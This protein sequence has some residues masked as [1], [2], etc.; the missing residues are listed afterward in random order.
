MNRTIKDIGIIL[1]LFYAIQ[2]VMTILCTT[3]GGLPMILETLRSY[4][5]NAVQVI[6]STITNGSQA[7]WQCIGMIL[8]SLITVLFLWK[9]NY[10]RFDFYRSWTTIPL[11]ILII[12]V[13]LTLS[14]MF[15]MNVAV[16]ALSLSDINATMFLSMSK[17]G[18]WG[19]L[20][21]A[22]FAPFAEEFTF[23]GA[24]E[25]LLLK[26]VRPWIAIL[27]SA[28]IFGLIHINPVQVVFS[29]A[30][31]ILLGWLYYKTNSI[32]PGILAHFIN[33]TC[34][35]LTLI[36]S[37]GKT[38]QTTE[39][40]LGKPLTYGLLLLS[41][42]LFIVLLFLLQRQLKRTIS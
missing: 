2:A 12:C 16:E 13:P 18:I 23:R 31:G 1:I 9:Y 26:S 20:C 11:R 29:F 7:L 19:F 24:I 32:V 21:I 33:N 10:V 35:F 30:L 14:A 5:D 8:S 41:V 17:T 3:I 27:V 6:L 4:P 39:E 15:I 36:M 25:G 34:G 42:I 22:V 38:P 28:F 37:D 40:F